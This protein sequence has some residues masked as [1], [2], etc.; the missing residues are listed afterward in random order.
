[1]ETNA[2]KRPS[3]VI[4]DSELEPFAGVAPSGVEA[5]DVTAV[6]LVK[7]F[8]QLRTN[9]S[10]APAGFGAVAPRFVAVE[11]NVTKSTPAEATA[12]FALGPLAGV[13]PSGVETRKVVGAH[14]D[15]VWPLQVSRRK[16]CGLMPSNV[17]LETRFVT[18]D[19]N[20]T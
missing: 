8:T 18:N 16:I 7:A 3:S 10:S 15:D 14:V 4:A 19:A 9:I 5:S 13:A 12:G 1:V 11:V 17:R 20:A 6:Q 2:I